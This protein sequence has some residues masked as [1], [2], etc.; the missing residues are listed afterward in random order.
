[1]DAQAWDPSTEEAGP[2]KLDKSNLAH[3][4]GRHSGQP[5]LYRETL[6]RKNKTKQTNKKGRHSNKSKIWQ[7]IPITPVLG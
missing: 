2:E 3:T 1:M 5:G 4:V 7:C 6:S